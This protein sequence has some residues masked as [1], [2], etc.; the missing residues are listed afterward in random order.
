[1]LVATQK[2][3]NKNLLAP[4]GSIFS[5]IRFSTNSYM[6]HNLSIELVII[7]DSAHENNSK[8]LVLSKYQG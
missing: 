3:K 2:I 5:S 6:N 7:Y 1:M 4:L 8:H